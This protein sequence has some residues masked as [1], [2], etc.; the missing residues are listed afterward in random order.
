MVHGLWILALTAL[1][2]LAEA[3]N[4]KPADYYP[5]SPPWARTSAVKLI[6]IR[7]SSYSVAEATDTLVGF[8]RT[9]AAGSVLGFSYLSNAGGSPY[10][11]VLS[12]A[13]VADFSVPMKVPP[14]LFAGFH[15][16]M[17]AGIV[18]VHQGKTRTSLKQWSQVQTLT[19]PEN[20]N[21]QSYFGNSIAVDQKNHTKVAVGCPGC[22]ATVNGG[23]V[24]LYSPNR[25]GT[26]W[27]QYQVLQLYDTTTKAGY[28]HLG[29]DVVL[30]DNVLLASVNLPYSGPQYK[31]GYVVYKQASDGTENF[32]PQQILSL[33]SGNLTAA[34]VYEETIVLS[35][36]GKSIAQY[37]RVGEVQIL[38]PITP[39]AT[40]SQSTY[41]WMTE[42]PTGQP[43]NQPSGQPTGQPTLQPTEHHIDESGSSEGS[44]LV[45]SSTSTSSTSW[46]VHQVLRSSEQADD[47]QFGASIALDGDTL[48]VSSLGTGDRTYIFRREEQYGKWSQQQVLTG[49]ANSDSVSIAGGAIAIS[50]VGLT[51]GA[52]IYTKQSNWDCLVISLEDHFGDGWDSA[53][54]IVSTPDG[55]HDYFSQGCDGASAVQFRYCPTRS[56]GGLYSFSIPQANKAKHYW[57]IQWGVF[58][59]KTGVW[60]RGK[61]D[62][63][64]DFHWDPDSLTFSPRKMERTLANSTFCEPC[65]SRPTEKPTPLHRNLKGSTT[66]SPTVSPAPTLDT[67][68]S[69]NWRYLTLYGDSHSWFDK[70]YQGTNYYV[71]D[72]RGH[73]LISTGTACTTG[74]D[75]KCW[76]DLPDGDYTLR[77]GGALD[78]YQTSH[79]FTF[80]KMVNQKEAGHQLMFRIKDDDC[81]I[82]TFASR[83]SVCQG[84]GYTTLSTLYLVLNVNILLHGT[85]ISTATSAEQTVFETALASL[86]HGVTASDV[87]L[88]SVSPVAES[89]TVVNANLR[90]SSAVGYN[91]LD[92]EEETSFETFLKDSFSSHALESNLVDGLS[93]GSVASAFAQVTKVEFLDYH[94]V[95]SVE[96]LESTDQ[97]DQ[98]TSFADFPSS[99]SDSSTD[100]DPSES[101]SETLP[102]VE[103]L[104]V[105]SYSGYFLAFLGIIFFL[106]TMSRKRSAVA[107]PPPA[108]RP[109]PMPT[110]AT[111]VPRTISKPLS[112]Q[113][114]TPRDLQELAAMEQEYLNLATQDIPT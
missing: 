15:T 23:Q 55:T 8:H 17:N 96:V 79:T 103:L 4:P 91:L 59:E 51:D 53:E 61:W 22:N 30:H 13:A 11:N 111:L 87:T 24:Y 52:L 21:Y 50:D 20:F 40:V 60:Y 80:C 44:T 83:N 57:E 7:G 66:R 33:K 41:V 54:L 97:I 99:E 94:L 49:V 31:Q 12:Y 84:Y 104:N 29:R 73:R 105:I 26:A 106:V 37:S 9:D 3:K 63:K 34:A 78:N 101:F 32:S 2:S 69:E 92:Y 93:S 110:Q 35:N 43:T 71:S 14:T 1:I 19:P 39:P 47:Y 28:R 100:A 86:F 88:V 90:M 85:A 113:T 76:L 98:L 72:A 70:Q 27:S 77:V 5:Y 16:N 64:M 10:T 109:S 108:T 65:P 89:N 18:R 6:D 95:D 112:C 68:N 62:T 36:S 81:S 102:A 82:V 67:T 45:S 25:R 56:D 114:L 48:V 46:Y 107:S 42:P 38:Y 75:Q 58:D 74:I